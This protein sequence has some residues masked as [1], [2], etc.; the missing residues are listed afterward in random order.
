MK[1]VISKHLK[2]IYED[3]ELKREATIAKYATVQ[4]ED[5]R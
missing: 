4:T 3:D 1:S 5:A 2:S